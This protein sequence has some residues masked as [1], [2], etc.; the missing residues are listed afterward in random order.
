MRGTVDLVELVGADAY[1]SLTLG[2]TLLQA[3][4]PA[5]LGCREGQPVWVTFNRRRL[6][7][8]S[9]RTGANLLLQSGDSTASGTL[10]LERT[11]SGGIR[12]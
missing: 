4:V 2:E 10:P 12:G 6:H 8:F 1:V 11:I 5:D 7:F 9:K 3:R